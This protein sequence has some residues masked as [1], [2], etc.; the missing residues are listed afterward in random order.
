[1][2]PPEQS[3]PQPESGLSFEGEELGRAMFYGTPLALIFVAESGEIMAMN[4][5]AEQ[6]TG[7]SQKDWQGAACEGLLRCRF[8]DEVKPDGGC[9]CIME[10][11][12]GRRFLGVLTRGN[13][14]SFVAEMVS[15]P[16]EVKGRRLFGVA[17]LRDVTA[18]EDR[19]KGLESRL[20][21]DALTGLGNRHLLDARWSEPELTAK[22]GAVL[23]LDVDRMK[24]INDL[25]GHRAGDEAL[26]MT[27][28]AITAGIRAGD[29]AVRHG[30][31][32]FLVLLPGAKGR[33]AEQVWQRIREAL[34]AEWAHS[35]LG[36]RVRVS[37][38]AG[39]WRPGEHPRAGEERADLKMYKDK[40]VI[41][42]HS[43]GAVRL[44][45]EGRRAVSDFEQEVVEEWELSRQ[46]AKYVAGFN[47]GDDVD[48]LMQRIFLRYVE[49]PEQFL[50]WLGLRPGAAV[51]EAGCG[52]GRLTF[53][54]G[55]AA[56]VGPGGLV[57]AC[58][59]S[60]TMLRQAW[61]KREER[62]LSNVY[63]L[64]A[65]A[66]K[67]PLRDSQV[68]Y[69]VGMNFLHFTDS[70][71]AVR[72][73]ARVTKPGGTVAL[74]V[75]TGARYPEVG[76][77][78]MGPIFRVVRERGMEYPQEYFNPPGTVPR[79]FERFGLQDVVAVPVAEPLSAV[80]FE[81]ISRFLSHAS[82]YEHLLAQL[83]EEDRA[84]LGQEV[85]EALRQAF[86][87][88][89]PED[90]QGLVNYEFVRGRVGGRG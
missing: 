21:V 37:C 43:S 50:G 65:P 45:E 14:G 39:L 13:G 82:F 70:E 74:I 19:R 42:M 84:C 3:R 86:E 71:R 17:I 2:V 83:S 48:A 22:G 44:T 80:S 10:A 8:P 4:P 79:L 31:D 32:E 66:E 18:E 57:L 41:L 38:G 77:K 28:R 52:G 47:S 5:R 9:R 35:G 53:E 90:L 76:I 24:E 27:A 85:E 26:Q 40:G 54:G 51:L 58:D 78:S 61:R 88:A 73:M 75:N 16:V 62:G 60:V 81:V 68:D 46:Q 1:M 30:G 12:S 34:E 7:W 15:Y 36:F 23:L 49:V 33:E 63:F 11:A 29:V 59:P 69:A 72:E 20:Y 25:F 6:L 55:L 87:T 67:L 64:K 56:R 89:C